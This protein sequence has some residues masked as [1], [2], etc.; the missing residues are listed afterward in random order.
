MRES[1]AT[2]G[3]GAPIA[4]RPSQGRQT[5]SLDHLARMGRV[6]EPRFWERR[7]RFVRDSARKIGTSVVQ[8]KRVVRGTVGSIPAR[9][10][11]ANAAAPPPPR[12]SSTQEF[13]LD[14]TAVW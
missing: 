2:L 9:A 4:L 11:C 14:Y 7:Y 6:W 3:G 10:S 8:G 1:A 5:P 12:H 13:G